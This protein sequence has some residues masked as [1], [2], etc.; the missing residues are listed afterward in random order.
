MSWLRVIIVF[1]M[2]SSI[3]PISIPAAASAT[4]NLSAPRMGWDFVANG[5][6]L[7][8]DTINVTSLGGD[9][10][11]RGV[12]IHFVPWYSMHWSSVDW[13]IFLVNVTGKD[14]YT[15]Y[16]YLDNQTHVFGLYL[17]HYATG[18]LEYL[19]FQGPEQVSAST[20]EYGRMLIPSLSIQPQ[21]KYSNTLYASGQSLQIAGNVGLL[22]GAR[23]YTLLNLYN[24]TAG[25][26][27]WNELWILKT[28]WDGVY[29]GTLYM[30]NDN[31]HTVLYAYDLKL[32]DLSLNYAQSPL[33]VA[34]SWQLGTP[35]SLAAPNILPNPTMTPIM[36]L[37]SL[38]C[39]VGTAS[40]LLR[41]KRF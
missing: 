32:N 19:A 6:T 17:F 5:S 1:L 38:L 34:A 24:V 16:L 37:L 11:V 13:L 35:R 31:R 9:L 2:F 20:V 26:S 30:L 40:F 33:N 7:A 27:S 14:F 36:L 21:A 28:A 3:H 25:G 29:F 23:I 22:E 41:K 8:N 18:D 15:A 12:G 10:V 39:V 4:P